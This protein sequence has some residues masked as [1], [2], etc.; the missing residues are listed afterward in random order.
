MT[1]WISLGEVPDSE[2][3]DAFDSQDSGTNPEQ[4]TTPIREASATKPHDIWDF[5]DSENAAEAIHRLPSPRG[6]LC[7]SPLS[8]AQSVDGM[9]ELDDMLLDGHKLSRAPE[10]LSRESSSGSTSRIVIELK[11]RP[12]T[13]I[14]GTP[15]NHASPPAIAQDI[16]LPSQELGLLET[17]QDLQREAVRLERSLRPRKP[18]QEHPYLLENAQY[19]SLIRQHGMRPVQMVAA[20]AKAAQDGND[21]FED[22]SQGNPF[23]EPNSWSQ[24]PN[25]NEM[26]EDRD[27]D[28]FDFPS[29]SP[30]KTSPWI[31]HQQNSNRGSSQ[32]D[33]DDTSQWGWR[34]SGSIIGTIFDFFG[35]QNLEHLRNEEVNA[36][37]K[38]LESLAEHP[39]LTIE[40]GD[41]CFHLFLKLLALSIQK[42]RAAGAINDIRNLVARIIPNHN[43]QHLKE[44]TVHERDLAA[45]RNHHDLL[46][47]LYWAAPPDMRPPPALIE[48]LVA[49]ETSHKE[50]SLINIR[51]WN[52]LSRFVVA[53]GEAATAFKPFHA[54]RNAFF[55]K[56]VQQFDSAAA[57]IQQQLFAL[58]SEVRHTVSEDVISS[59]I[60][61]N[62]EAV[63]DVLRASIAASLDVMKHA[64]DLEAATFCLNTLQLQ[65]IYYQFGI[66]PPE[67]NW[68]TLRGAVSTLDL[69]VGYVT[70]FKE[71]EE[72]QQSE[73]Q[74]LNSA[75]ADDALLQLDRE[76][77]KKFFHMVRCI[78]SNSAPD[79]G[80][81]EPYDF[82][83]IEQAVDVAVRLA[84]SFISGGLIKLQDLFKR[85][86]Y[87]LFDGPIHKMDFD[88]R[89]YL[90]LAVVILL[91]ASI[92]NFADVD[93]TLCELWL[94]VL[95]RPSRG[96]NR[97]KQLVDKYEKRLA[98]VL[99]QRGE[100]F[101]PPADIGQ[102]S[103]EK[104]E[105]NAT[106]FEF[107]ISAMRGTTRDAEA[108]LK[109]SLT[110]EHSRAL[111]LV[112][113]QMKDDL[114]ATSSRP[115]THVAYVAFARRIVSLIRT[116]GSEICAIDG[117]YYQISKDYSPSVGD[118]QLQIAA[119]VSY[120]LR[121]REDDPK[122]VQ[123]VF[124][125]LFNNFKLALASDD[126]QEEQKKLR[127]GMAQDRGI[128]QFIIGKMLPAILEATASKAVAYP[129][130]DLYVWVAAR[131][132]SRFP[133][134]YRLT[135][136]DLFGV[137]A[138]LQAVLKG[139]DEWIVGRAPLTA[140]GLH[141][142]RTF[143]AAINLLWPSIYEYSLG[144]DGLLEP[145]SDIM[146][147]I[148]MLNQYVIAGKDVLAQ[149]GFR[150][151]R[152]RFDEI[153]A[154]APVNGAPN[155]AVTDE[156]VRGFADNIRQD[157]DRSW[158]EAEGRISIQMPGKPRGGGA[159]QGVLQ[160][161]WNEPALIE[162][163]IGQLSEW[164][165]WKKKMDLG[166]NAPEGSWLETPM[167]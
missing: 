166:K 81:T 3:E 29:S 106:L 79:R 15:S 88:R 123:Q 84:A 13:P 107:A 131:R 112:M 32:D 85:G 19:S 56:M 89:Q 70:E 59:M 33:T 164:L 151:S 36:S 122:V 38:F 11:S 35:S 75:Q 44:Q 95:I 91:K 96:P 47:T 24:L 65:H 57:D 141:I 73:S 22:D 61:M 66:Y 77:S 80:S 138:V 62:K 45:L 118:P 60:S 90:V 87:G 156:D 127:K 129:L 163:V 76:V 41:Q 69:F 46:A 12:S 99:R 42:L 143:F 161:K 134:T 167:F 86:K 152:M 54:W 154:A 82:G 93:F 26:N 63:G 113:E 117:F 98:D 145:R 17:T 130:M 28:M 124:F 1:D 160:P 115:A 144:Q 49:P 16:A 78:L 37:P 64:V 40:P 72:T 51:C 155:S 52:Q 25:I 120:G 101:L 116:H 162:G 157:V 100:Y 8:S 102:T 94:L 128:T 92:D 142:F 58:P 10:A 114:R 21:E 67:L 50:A 7:S 149:E 34:R 83:G 158:F 48:R 97:E 121:L 31:S 132:L 4:T 71:N 2:D 9:L 5:P 109:R 119:M 68:N 103:A 139:I 135:D 159:L 55:Q 74:I 39:S 148:E 125:F 110:A 6:S 150:S 146:E 137:K 153:F 126:L 136:A 140:K 43:R 27:I 133:M 23:P 105:R 18:I 53:K 147:L 30:P 111:K 104:Y 14:G 108:S 20:R 165:R